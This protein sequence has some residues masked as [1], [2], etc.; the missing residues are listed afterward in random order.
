MF[1]LENLPASG[2]QAASE[3]KTGITAVGVV[4]PGK[5]IHNVLLLLQGLGDSMLTLYD[6]FS[7]FR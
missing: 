6:Q 5:G 1:Y 3:K 2:R 7:Q 4:W